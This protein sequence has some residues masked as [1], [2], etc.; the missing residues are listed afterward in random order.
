M[1]FFSILHLL[2]LPLNL[3]RFLMFL[4]YKNKQ[5][6]FPFQLTSPLFLFLSLVLSSWPEPFYV[7][8]PSPSLNSKSAQFPFGI[9]ENKGSAHFHGSRWLVVQAPRQKKRRKEHKRFSSVS[10]FFCLS[11]GISVFTFHAFFQIKV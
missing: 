1:S 9:P 3:V 2:L 4:Q 10:Y 5:D 8:P 11:G 6:F 7:W